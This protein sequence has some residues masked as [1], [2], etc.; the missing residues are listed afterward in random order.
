MKKFALSLACLLALSTA[1]FAGESSKAS[2]KEL[3]AA[4]RALGGSNVQVLSRSD[5]SKIRGE[6]GCH[7]CID[8]HKHQNGKGHQKCKTNHGHTK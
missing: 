2:T 5:A 8:T 7:S 4:L 3:P 1:A 6:G